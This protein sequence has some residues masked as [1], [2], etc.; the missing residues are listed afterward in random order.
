MLTAAEKATKDRSADRSNGGDV[1]KG[2]DRQA[3]NLLESAIIC[4]DHAEPLYKRALVIKEKAL[5]SDHP[6]VA[7][8]LEHYAELLKATQRT[9]EAEAMLKRA[10]VMRAKK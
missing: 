10:A 6:N 2:Y 3:R 1:L 5:G 4:K 7:E 8:T 9:A